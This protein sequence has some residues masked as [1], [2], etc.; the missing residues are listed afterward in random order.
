M[1]IRPID[2]Q[3][4]ITSILK[5]YPF[6]IADSK[7]EDGRYS[8]DCD[9]LGEIRFGPPYFSVSVFNGT[10]KIWESSTYGG[11]LFCNNIISARCN[12]LVLVKWFSSSDPDKQVVTEIDL[13]TGKEKYLTEEG[14]YT[15]AG[16][17]DS[18]DGIF[19]SKS[20]VNDTICL[21]R[22]TQETFLLNET[23]GKDIDN[24][25]SWGLSPVEN[26]IIVISNSEK[27]NVIL[28]DLKYKKILEAISMPYKLS[29]NGDARCFLDKE[30]RS[31]LIELSDYDLLEDRTIVNERK[32]Y[33]IVEF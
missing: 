14:R 2:D 19:Y 17:F 22:E 5:K 26:T 7:I 23:L 4:Y 11:E 12:K 32:E 30:K 9:Y 24:V 21:D 28:Y 33:R 31:V 16:H 6:T 27:E 10:K 8:I 25:F 13:K 15:Y 3:E 29:E 20:G 1:T 18:F